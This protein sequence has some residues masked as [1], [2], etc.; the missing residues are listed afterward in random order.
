MK[1]SNSSR[2]ARRT[3]KQLGMG[4]TT[5]IEISEG[6]FGTFKIKKWKRK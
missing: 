5:Q 2:I 3:K 6:K 4:A 1:K